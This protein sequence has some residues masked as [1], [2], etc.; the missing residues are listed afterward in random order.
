[1]SRV[2]SLTSMPEA[3]LNRWI[4]R[5]A[6]LFVVVLIAF[7]AFYVFDRY[8]PIAPTSMA[9]QRIAEME[10]AVAADPADIASRGTLADLY[11]ETGRYQDAVAQYDAI[12]VTGKQEQLA[13]TG[14]AK[15]YEALGQPD[16]A[17]TDWQWVIDLLKDS[18]MAA[19]DPNLASAYYHAGTIAIAGG[20]VQD[21]VDNLEK[22]VAIARADSDTLYALGNAYLTLNDADKAI[23][24]FTR[25]AAFVP[26]GWADPYTGLAAAYAKKGDADMSAWANAMATLAQGDAKNAETQLNALLGG[27]ADIPASMG[28][29]LL[30]EATGEPENAVVHYQHVLETDPGNKEAQLGMARVRPVPTTAPAASAAPSPSAEGSN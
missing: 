13:R 6:L 28:L 12:I 5:I 20:K 26:V 11:T 29:G 2:T 4:K 21:G 3:Q 22:S 14:R 18:E 8:N 30:G 27:P 10:K 23:D 7:V 25:A 16:A 1:M 17:M 15:A 19:Q 9:D 24:R